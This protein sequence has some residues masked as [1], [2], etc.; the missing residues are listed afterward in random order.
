VVWVFYTFGE[1]D[2]YSLFAGDFYIVEHVQTEAFITILEL[3]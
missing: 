2:K 3:D 1:K